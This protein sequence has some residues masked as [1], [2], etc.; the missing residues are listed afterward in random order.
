MAYRCA[1]AP[2]FACH[3]RGAYSTAANNNAAV[4]L[5]VLNRPRDW[6]GKV[7]VVVIGIQFVGAKVRYLVTERTDQLCDLG[8]DPRSRRGLPRLP[9][10]F[11]L[12]P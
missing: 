5:A 8:F 7:R 11:Q 10:S 9:L 3:Y 6:R 2:E 12:R 4:G 1:D